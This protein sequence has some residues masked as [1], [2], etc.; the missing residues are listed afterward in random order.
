MQ[1]FDFLALL[2]PLKL[3]A[4]RFKREG[5]I[6]RRSKTHVKKKKGSSFR[7]SFNLGYGNLTKTF[8]PKFLIKES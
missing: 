8:Q 4:L 2:F 7:H 5:H 3:V 1:N 6:E